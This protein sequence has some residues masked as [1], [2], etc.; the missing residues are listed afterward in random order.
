MERIEWV[1]SG[2]AFANTWTPEPLIEDRVR[3]WNGICVSVGQVVY[4]DEERIVLGITHDPEHNAW[5]ACF[6]IQ[7]RCIVKRVALSQLPETP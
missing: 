6:G 7:K 4:E 1:D 3:D 5:A 2:L